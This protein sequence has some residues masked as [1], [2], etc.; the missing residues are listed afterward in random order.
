M[1]L[2][3]PKAVIFDWDNTLVTS[4]N[5]IADAINRTRE[6]FGQKTWSMDEIRIHCTRA[7]RE[8]FPEWFGDRWREAYD[9]YYALVGKTRLEL[10][11]PSNGALELLNLL[12]QK[13]I[14]LFIVS[15]LR[16]DLLRIEVD[17]MQWRSY[18][19]AIAG[20]QD[21][22][23]DKPSREHADFALKQGGLSAHKDIWFVG[24]SEVDMLCARNSGCT[25]A[26]IGS[27][28]AAKKL[29][30]ELVFPDC[31]ALQE[32]LYNIML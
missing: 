13:N 28:D 15:N 12:R 5:A 4:W 16:G 14:P 11:S 32:L 24:D 22:P 21:A 6:K 17:K 20:A 26:L 25:P 1:N 19:V 29:G 18:F 8:S 2:E 9:F 7:A 27:S 10:I 23:R 3:L 30:I 31:H